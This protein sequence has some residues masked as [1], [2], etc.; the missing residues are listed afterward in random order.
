MREQGGRTLTAGRRQAL[1][2][3]AFLKTYE[4]PEVV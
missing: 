3:A 4:G 2:K 1:A